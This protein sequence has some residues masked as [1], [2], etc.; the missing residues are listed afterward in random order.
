M[1]LLS[2]TVCAQP[3]TDYPCDSLAVRAILD[4]NGLDSTSVEAVASGLDGR[5]SH[6]DFSTGHGDRITHPCGAVYFGPRLTRLPSDI[7][8]LSVLQGL[9]LPS[10][11]DEACTLTIAPEIGNLDSLRHLRIQHQTTVLPPELGGLVSLTHL[12]IAD[13]AVGSIPPELGQLRSLEVLELCN[14]DI[15][16]LPAS[17]GDLENLRHLRVRGCGL[18]TLPETILGLPA[19]EEVNVDSNYL[20]SL[21]PRIAEWLDSLSPHWRG[22]QRCTTSTQPARAGQ[23]AVPVIHVQGHGDRVVIVLPNA[24][25][26]S[27]RLVD[28]RGRSIYAYDGGTSTRGQVVLPARPGCASSGRFVCVVEYEGQRSRHILS[29][30]AQRGNM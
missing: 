24:G 8:R 16:S 20:C 25:R 7:G 15:D 27:A 2:G 22:G 11:L 5:V 13:S 29:L 21:P 14:V 9:V 10:S 1:L 23:S 30:G 4:T 19:L 18:R 3:C 17:I 26:V 6:L 12:T 28:M